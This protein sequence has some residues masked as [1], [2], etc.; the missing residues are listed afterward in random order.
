M[1]QMDENT[2]KAIC[3]AKLNSAVGWTGGRLS[4]DRQQAMKYYRGDL[5]G[6]EV[7]KRSKVV[8][9]D[10]AEAID[11]V[12]PGLIKVFATTDTIV[13][14]EPRTPE[15]EPAAK[16]ATDYLNWV[17]QSQPNAF[18]LLQDWI[19]DGLLSKLGV[20]KSWWDEQE[21]V[22]SE[23]YEGLT[24]FQYQTLISDENVE[25]VSVS[26]RPI[27]PDMLAMMMGAPGPQAGPPAPQPGPSPVPAMPPQDMLAPAGQEPPPGMMMPPGMEDGLLYDCKI[28]RINRTGRIS[29]QAVPPEEFLTER[30]AVSLKDATF[31]AHRARRTVS[32]L[33]EMGYKKDV[34][35]KLPGGD[36]L[37]FNSEVVTRFELDDEMPEQDDDTLDESMRPIWYV[38][39]YLKVDF[40][41]DGIAEW[42]KVCLGGGGTFEILSNEECDGHPFSAWTPNKIPHKL[43]GESLADKTMDLQ[44]IK[45]TVWRQ[46]MDGMFFNNAPQL[47]VM[48][49]QTNMEDA[50]TRVP[51]G[52][53][54]VKQL[55]AV[56][57]LPVVDT[58]ASSM[59][60]I[61]YL[62]SVREARTGTRRFGPALDADTL[63][64]YAQ[65]A[66][67]AQL[68]ED[69]SQ[70][71][72][73][74]MARNF[75]EQGL[76]PLFNRLLELTIKHQDKPTT[77]KLRGQWVD[78][79]PSTW[80]TKMDMTVVVGLGTGNRDTQVSQ[81]MTM[82]TQV[83][84]AIVQAQGGMNGPLINW[85]NTHN[86]LTKL[87]E[88]MGYRA[89]D[90]FYS[91]PATA[92]PP[93]PPPPDPNMQ[94]AQA[95]IEVEK[96]KAERK[97]EL[98]AADAARKQQMA[99]EKAQFD[100]WL[101]QRRAEHAMA[102]EEMKAANAAGVAERKEAAR[103]A[104]DVITKSLGGAQPGMA[105]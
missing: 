32:D 78:I 97:A 19:K 61:N 45:S 34:V 22:T 16:Q 1:A 55:G 59:A 88:A 68:I 99:R 50:L 5:F 65:T 31:C 73:M 64:P 49:G 66:T 83:D 91:D 23:E 46:A 48:E 96:F 25:P 15:D 75:A 89:A 104:A 38:E 35:E 81:L 8:S 71:R 103:V 21:E 20:V 84:A 33:L 105:M 70:D 101:E 37:D 52:V 95:Q 77:V 3:D 60:M 27:P 12:E 7:D 86:K 47:V 74:L 90:N 63:N 62:D 58:S 4:Q 76:K 98:D 53:I 57:P 26:T 94:I 18:E 28:K 2:L 82:L 102:L 72:I 79:D 85:N 17:F 6:N 44:L 42:R 92:P 11:S 54:R 9:R 39:A 56:T 100:M 14:C 87:T 93:P 29:I 41:G 67:G 13:V 36:D 80:T 40:D 10:V 30:R 69:S 51:G 43:Y 24:K